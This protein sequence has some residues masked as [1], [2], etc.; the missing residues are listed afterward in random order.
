MDDACQPVDQKE[1]LI[2][3]SGSRECQS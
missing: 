3:P 1:D 2:S